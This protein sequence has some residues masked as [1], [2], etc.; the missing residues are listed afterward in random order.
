MLGGGR[1]RLFEKMLPCTRAIRMVLDEE[2]L[3][4]EILVG[5]LWME[6]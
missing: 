4:R 5:W 6:S 1:R 2:S 3:Y